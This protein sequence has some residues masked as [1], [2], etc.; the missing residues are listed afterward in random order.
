M[1]TPTVRRI[2]ARIDHNTESFSATA[3]PLPSSPETALE[4]AI[5]DATLPRLRAVLLQMVKDSVEASDLA[6]KALLVASTSTSPPARTPMRDLSVNS[7]LND[8][9]D[10]DVT[11]HCINNGTLIQAGHSTPGRAG[12]NRKRKAYEVCC[13]CQQEYHVAENGAAV[14]AYHP[15]Q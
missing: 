14:C 11:L 3:S 2:A 15:G 4:E 7:L 12:G 6:S 8:T 13:N 5:W 9:N 10:S 1:A